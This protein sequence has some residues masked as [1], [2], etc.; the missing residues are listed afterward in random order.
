LVERL[1]TVVQPVGFSPQ[2]YLRNKLQA[3]RKIHHLSTCDTCQRIINELGLK[4]KGFEFQD[5]KAENIAAEELDAAKE[6]VGSYEA[7]FSK[8]AM[9]YRS[10]GLNEMDLTEADYRKYM[11]EEYTFLKRP[12]IW[13]DDELFVGNSKK[14]VAAAAEKLG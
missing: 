13:I 8:R 3:M 11:L 1:F 2:V 14:V 7:L 9:K 12:F 5:I 10:M 6:K 4:E